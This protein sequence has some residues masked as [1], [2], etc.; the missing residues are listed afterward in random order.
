MADPQV[1]AVLI[2]METSTHAKL[3]LERSRRARWVLP[4]SRGP[5]GNG[6]R[7]HLRFRP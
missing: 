4:L 5:G 1:D 7:R 6:S 2:A 3:P